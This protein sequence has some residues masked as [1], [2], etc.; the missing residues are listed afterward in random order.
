MSKSTKCCH[1]RGDQLTA[2]VRIYQVGCE[3]SNPVRESNL[4]HMRPSPS[5][6]HTRTLTHS[7]LHKAT[8]QGPGRT[9]GER[10]FARRSP[11]SE[12]KLH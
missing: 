10:G 5:G 2:R 9:G 4:I 7:L 12:L 1:C 6:S 8:A 3:H 11:S